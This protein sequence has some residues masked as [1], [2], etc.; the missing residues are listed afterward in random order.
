[1][2]KVGKNVHLIKGKQMISHYQMFAF[3]CE[4]VGKGAVLKG[5]SSDFDSV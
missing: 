1:M 4:N 5:Q 3:S 2:G